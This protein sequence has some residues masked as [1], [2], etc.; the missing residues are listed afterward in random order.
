MSKVPP[1][2]LAALLPFQREGV[3]FCLERHA[4]SLIAD[5]VSSYL[6]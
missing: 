6:D 2:L 1:S 4:R 3:R 5:E